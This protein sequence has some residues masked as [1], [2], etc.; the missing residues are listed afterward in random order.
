ML[1]LAVQASNDCRFEP[2]ITSQI[3]LNNQPHWHVRIKKK[4][5]SLMP[6]AP[7][8]S[9]APPWP[10][11][12]C[13]TSKAVATTKKATPSANITKKKVKEKWGKQR[14]FWIALLARKEPEC[15]IL[16]KICELGKASRG[17]V[18]GKLVKRWAA[19]KL[20]LHCNW[21][22]GFSTFQDSLL[23]TRSWLVPSCLIST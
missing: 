11:T 6:I 18:T 13:S 16:N 19:V 21:T 12:W 14:Q 7:I 15:S 1:K 8:L 17:A 4:N 22:H 5:G 2:I 10:H 3:K 23:T 9:P 20:H